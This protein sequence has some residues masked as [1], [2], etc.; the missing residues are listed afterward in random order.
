MPEV[1][2]SRTLEEHEQILALEWVPAGQGH[3]WQRSSKIGD[4][5]E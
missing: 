2:P 4:L 3:D 1:E 5:S